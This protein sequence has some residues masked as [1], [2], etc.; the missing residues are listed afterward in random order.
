MKKA[1]VAIWTIVLV[2]SA[3][4]LLLLC[5][6]HLHES[7]YAL[8]EGLY[9]KATA[10]NARAIIDVL[11]LWMNMQSLNTFREKWQQASE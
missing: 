11:F 2:L 8:G 6:F 10:L 9:H 3:I 4:S 5:G 1:L 7:G